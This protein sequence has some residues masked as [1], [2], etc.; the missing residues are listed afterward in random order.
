M[1][2][3]RFNWKARECT[4]FS[5]APNRGGSFYAS[6]QTIHRNVGG[7]A[8]AELAKPAS[9]WPEQQL[10]RPCGLSIK[11]SWKSRKKPRGKRARKIT[12]DSGAF[13]L[14]L[15]A[16]TSTRNKT[17]HCGD[18]GDDQLL[19]MMKKR[20]HAKQ[21]IQVKQENENNRLAAVIAVVY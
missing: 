1:A 2:W 21:I 20:D 4:P 16:L 19:N 17:L 10:K 8:C 15:F 14:P 7:N 11:N 6:P 5:F 9:H 13:S 18:N 3:H 12:I